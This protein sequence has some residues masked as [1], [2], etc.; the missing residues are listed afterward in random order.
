M[1][2]TNGLMT[3]LLKSVQRIE[4]SQTNIEKSQIKMSGDIVQSHSELNAKLDALDQKTSFQVKS[5]TERSDHLDTHVQR[6]FDEHGKRIN[7]LEEKTQNLQTAQ[8]KT[9]AT[10]GFIATIGGA[11]LSWLRAK[12]F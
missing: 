3:E 9:H 4:T 5:L 2:D 10:V 12:F 8:I 7:K 11:V 1:T 6:E